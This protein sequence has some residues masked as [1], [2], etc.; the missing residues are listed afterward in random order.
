MAFVKAFKCTVP[1]KYVQDV[2]LE[3]GTYTLGVRVKDELRSEYKFALWYDDTWNEHA[4]PLDAFAWRDGVKLTFTLEKKATKFSLCSVCSVDNPVLVREPMLEHGTNASTPRPNDLDLD[5]RVD[6][7]NAH[8]PRVSDT[9]GNWEVWTLQDGVWQYVDTGKTSVGDDGKAP[10]V[11]AD[12][13]WYEWD[14]TKYVKTSYKAQGRDGL[15]G[16]D[17]H[18]SRVNIPVQCNSSGTPVSFANT[19]L[20]IKL[21]RGSYTFEYT[22]HGASNVGPT[23]GDYSIAAS[24]DGVSGFVLPSGYQFEVNIGNISGL[25]KDVG[26]VTLTFTIYDF[27][28]NSTYQVQRV[29]TY[30]KVKAGGDGQPGRGIVA[31]VDYYLATNLSTGVTRNTSGWKTTV[32]TL[33]PANNFL[34]HYRRT[35]YTSAPVYEY[36]DP[37]IIGTYG[38][39][40]LPGKMPIKREW[41]QG[42]THRNNDEVVDYIYYRG[43]KGGTH[44][45]TWWRLKDGKTSNTAPASPDSNYVQLSQFDMLAVQILIAEEA[46]VGGFIFK[47]N[48]FLSQRGKLTDGTYANF[49]NQPGWTP[50]IRLNGVDGSGQLGCGAIVWND[51]EVVLKAGVVT[52]NNKFKVLED[53][54]IEAVDG[55]FAGTV[56]SAVSGDRITISAAT[57]SLKMIDTLDRE[58]VS[59]YFGTVNTYKNPVLKMSAYVGNQTTENSRATIDGMGVEVQHL[60]PNRY[61]GR[62]KSAL[63]E[64]YDSVPGSLFSA[65]T[66]LANNS[67]TQ[68]KLIVRMVNLPTSAAGLPTGALYRS[69]SNIYITT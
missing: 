52:V 7:I 16:L 37:T 13:Y 41:V 36:T 4:I 9:T 31:E 34:W 29:I 22:G 40:G 32:Q 19:G 12:G 6:E 35:Q 26:T 20:K 63:V 69:G 68:N 30:S 43:V 8:P 2:V 42:E 11:G 54:S 10:I 14:G 51:S 44:Y 53:G 64:V 55:K 23:G 48:Q 60:D 1:N 33:T 5:E 59:M 57:K 25:S 39:Q 46:N 15:D 61:H 58:F 47:E 17:F 28:S 3:P 56:E 38:T 24:T 27:R 62:L 50:N 49:D 21:T 66:N 18:I 65:Q 67:Y 45:N